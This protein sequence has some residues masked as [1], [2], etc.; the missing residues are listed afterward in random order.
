MWGYFCSVLVQ[1]KVKFGV[2]T[3]FV[4]TGTLTRQRFRLKNPL[5]LGA[6]LDM[7]N[8]K[9]TVIYYP[10]FEVWALHHCGTHPRN[11]SSACVYL[12]AYLCMTLQETEVFRWQNIPLTYRA[13]VPMFTVQQPENWDIEYKEI[14]NNTIFTHYPTEVGTA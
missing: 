5:K 8:L 2:V 13:I 4:A 6:S 10:P 9:F 12:L 3:P 7:R 14:K 1:S 11:S